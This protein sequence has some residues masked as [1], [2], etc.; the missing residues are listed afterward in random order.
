MT[1]FP[2]RFMHSAT[3]YTINAKL[4]EVTLFGGSP[5][6]PKK[7]RNDND[8]IFL[9]DTTVLRF[10]KYMLATASLSTVYALCNLLREQDN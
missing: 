10:G 3:A 7:Y 9:S 8:F 4:T 2:T 6:W 5:E 1:H